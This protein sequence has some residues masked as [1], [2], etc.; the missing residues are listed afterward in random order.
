MIRSDPAE[1]AAGHLAAGR[2]AEAKALFENLLR[3]EPTHVRALC[4]LGTIA[5]GGGETARALE[6]IGHAVAIAPTD[7]MTVGNLGV[8]YL[9]QNKLAEAENCF[10]RALDLDPTR[11]DLHANFANALLARGDLK[12]AIKAQSRAVELAP[13]SATQLYNLG[14]ILAAS[15]QSATAGDAYAATLELDPAHVGALNNLSILHKQAGRLDEAAALLDEALLHDPMNPELLANQADILLQHD[16]P[17][18]ALETMRRAVGLAPGNALLR[19]ALGTLLLELGQLAEAGQELAGAMR[20]APQNPN[21]ALTLARLLRR[22]GQL[23][24]AQTAADRAESLS[25]KPGAAGVLATELLLMRG[26]Y[27]EAWDRL[28]RL[29]AVAEHPLAEPDLDNTAD[30]SGTAIRLIAVDATISVFAAR[31][32]PALAARG[33]LLTVIAPPILAPLMATVP[34]VAEALPL[35]HLDLAALADDGTPSLLLDALPRR[36]RATPGDPA[37]ALPVFN[38]QPAADTATPDTQQPRRVGIWWEGPGPGTALLQTLSGMQGAQLVSLQS[39]RPR[40]VARDLLAASGAV[41]RGETIDDFRDLA[42]AIRTVDVL[43]APD[44]PVAH[45]AASLGIE[46]WVLVGR[47][48]SWSWPNEPHPSPWYPTGRAFRQSIN[49]TWNV[50]LA[51]LRTALTHAPGTSDG[52]VASG[53]SA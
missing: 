41:D 3:I 2:V 1:I 13:D 45:L 53:D 44:G 6:L 37:I 47:D 5:L 22:Q 17:D 9:A 50:A 26:H 14:N 32:I 16:H 12:T 8:A 33:A 20:A 24:A 19:L 51:A 21:I 11:P 42:A 48:G 18:Q 52:P 38:V 29:A 39:G 36:L 10:R 15:G 27:A 43:I 30:L 7:G 31:F 23:D 4:G 34:G 35:E 49:G 46:T 40:H 28:D 25:A